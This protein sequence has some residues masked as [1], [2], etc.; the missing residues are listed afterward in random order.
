MI[1]NKTNVSP[2]SYSISA[3]PYELKVDADINNYSSKIGCLDYGSYDLSNESINNFMKTCKETF[4]LNLQKEEK[5]DM[6][7]TFKDFVP[8]PFG[9]YQKTIAYYKGG[10]AVKTKSG[11][12]KTFVADDTLGEIKSVENTIDF[13]CVIAP[14]PVENIKIGDLIYVDDQFYF[15][16]NFSE[17]KLAF[18]MIDVETNEWKQFLPTTFAGKK[19]FSKVVNPLGETIGEFFKDSAVKDYF[20]TK[21]KD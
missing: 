3:T 10:I 12:Y 6:I 16:E 19:Y 8:L 2:T 13:P 7:K 17:K 9:H 5:K 21:D 11:V 4:E 15:V 14:T 18:S 20:S 1:V